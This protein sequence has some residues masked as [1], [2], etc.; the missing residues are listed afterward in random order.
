M[1]TVESVLPTKTRNPELVALAHKV[2][3]SR[4]CTNVRLTAAAQQAT[5]GSVAVDT[6]EPLLIS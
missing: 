1:T 5:V 6:G 2:V 3:A 4:S